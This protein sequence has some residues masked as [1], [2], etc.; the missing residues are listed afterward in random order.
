MCYYTSTFSHANIFYMSDNHQRYHI[1][2]NKRPGGVTF[3]QRG[4]FKIYHIFL[5]K[6]KPIFFVLVFDPQNDLLGGQCVP[7][8]IHE[9]WVFCGT[10][11]S[12]A[13]ALSE[14][15]KNSKCIERK[16]ITSSY[17]ILLILVC[18][19]AGFY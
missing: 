5:I 13:Q 11:V 6:L 7:R 8:K 15:M 12:P 10:H 4:A 16:S 9:N 14:N 18:L 1:Y 2:P 3:C 19:Y 17:V